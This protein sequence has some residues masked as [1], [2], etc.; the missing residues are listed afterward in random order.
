MSRLENGFVYLWA[1]FSVALSG[2]I[3]A[4]AA[5]VWQAKSQRDKE[6]ELLFIGEQFR[7]AIMSYHNTGTKQYPEKLEDLLQDSRAI[8]IQRHIRKIYLDPITNSE[9]WGLIEETPANTQAGAAA[10]QS[11]AASN[12]KSG[13]NPSSTT[14]PSTASGMGATSGAGTTSNNPTATANP[15]A[16]TSSGL[17]PNANPATGSTTGPASGN[18]PASTTSSGMSSNIGKR[19]IGVYSLSER[20][21]IK[22]DKFPEVYAKFS[23]AKTYQDWKFIYKP[24]EGTGAKGAAS[25]QNQPSAS[26]AAPAKGSPLSPQSSQGSSAS[27]F[28]SPSSPAPAKGASPFGSQ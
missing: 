4:G 13:T 23:E 28:A 12:Q 10:S 3:M 8:N 11:N 1:L 24:G 25:P 16:A 2:V 5:Q 9:E 7:K 17:A 26:G 18:N 19:I 6:A 27:P 15:G 21:P 20:K 14:N 22:K